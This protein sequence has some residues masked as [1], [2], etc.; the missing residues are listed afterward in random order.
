MR[1]SAYGCSFL[2]ISSLLYHVRVCFSPPLTGQ[3]VIENYLEIQFDLVY[4]TKLPPFINLGLLHLELIL[5]KDHISYE[6]SYFILL[7]YLV[8]LYYDPSFLLT[9]SDQ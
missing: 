7:F 2:Y 9:Q 6:L 5:M 1:K 3:S 4:S 8:V